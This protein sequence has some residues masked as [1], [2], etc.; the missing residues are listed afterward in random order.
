MSSKC[1]FKFKHNAARSVAQY[2]ARIVAKGY[3]HIEGLDYDETFAPV[4]QYDSLRLTIDITTHLGL[5][6]DQL[7]IKSEFL[8]ADLVEEIWMVHLL[9]IGLDGKILRLYKAHHGRKKPL[10]T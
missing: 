7:S 3:S 2:Q 6:T 1:I 5:D 10:L 8:N 9:A 4:T